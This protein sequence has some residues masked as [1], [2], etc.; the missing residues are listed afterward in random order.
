MSLFSVVVIDFLGLELMPLAFGMTVLLV[1]LTNIG[2]PSYLGKCTSQS[3]YYS[4][5][6]FNNLVDWLWHNKV[7]LTLKNIVFQDICET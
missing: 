2:M 1:G 7:V 5:K 4:V 3:L 6:L